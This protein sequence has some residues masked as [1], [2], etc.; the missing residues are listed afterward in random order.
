MYAAAAGQEAEKAEVG[1][2]RQLIWIVGVGP[3]VGWGVI[4]KRESI[5]SSL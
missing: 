5:K 1:D 2:I 3:K 4:R